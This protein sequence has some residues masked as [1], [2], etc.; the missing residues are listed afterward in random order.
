MKKT[1]I[2][3]AA[4]FAFSVFTYA[5]PRMIENVKKPSPTVLATQTFKA[6]YDGGMFGYNSKEEGTIRFDDAN[7][8]IVF[9]DKNN[10]ELF[11]IS[12]DAMNLIYPNSQSV[13][14][15]GG[16][17]MQNVP[18]P[19]A[20]IA[21]MFMKEKRRYMVINFDDVLM[22]SKGTVNF[23]LENREKLEEIIQAVGY[24]AELKQRGD[25][26]YR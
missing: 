2:L 20:G 13:Q 1:F 7:L 26:F 8:R 24:K 6:K 18:L 3:C 5:Q 15:T 9:F 23:K 25:S 14:S 22:K 17:V 19:G 4:I 12:Y 16:K 21:G 10:K 11:G